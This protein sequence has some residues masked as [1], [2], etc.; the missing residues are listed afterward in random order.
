[1]PARKPRQAQMFAA[2]C[3]DLPLFSGTAPRVA[4]EVF[5]PAG[6]AQPRLIA[7]PDMPTLAAEFKANRKETK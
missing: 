3:A 7:V 6:P 5:E 2:S 1:M 4:V